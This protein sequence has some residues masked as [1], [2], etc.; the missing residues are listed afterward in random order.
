MAGN[1]PAHGNADNTASAVGPPACRIARFGRVVA[2]IERAER[3]LAAAFGF[4]TIS[5]AAGDSR[6]A[7]LLGVPGAMTRR[8]HMRLGDQEI[9]LTA[10]DP[11]GRPYPPG[12]HELRPVVP[13]P[14][15]RRGRHRR[16]ACPGTRRPTCHADHRGRPDPPALR[17]RRRPGVQISRR[18]RSPA[19]AARIPP[20]IHS[21][22]LA[23]ASAARTSS[24][25]SITPRSPSR[26]P[27]AASAS[28]G[29][30][31]A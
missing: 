24:S 27:G 20:G 7:E 28:S 31:S 18:R 29:L 2:D 23:P 5:R 16:G 8:T 3:F 19:R 1:Q 4:T 25:E 6:F 10:F 15:H 14:G 26:T 22:G 11:P 12:Q 21:R 30:R 9:A 17:L 13:A